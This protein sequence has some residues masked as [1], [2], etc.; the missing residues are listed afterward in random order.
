MT[1]I[2]I[3][4]LIFLVVLLIAA[5]FIVVAVIFQK[6]GEDGLSSSIAG[7]AETYYGKDKSV[8]T[9]KLLFKGTLIAGIVFV[10]ATLLVFILQPD[11][12]DTINY[13]LWKQMN[14]FSYI[15]GE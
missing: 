14:S 2:E 6:T 11:Y 5:V 8:H 7:G 9:D 4:S 13:D 10:V 12:A 1:P 15:F 3:I